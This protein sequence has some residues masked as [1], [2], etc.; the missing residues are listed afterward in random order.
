MERERERLAAKDKNELRDAISIFQNNAH[1][2]KNLSE[3]AWEAS[4]IRW[5]F[6][7]IGFT[8]I[9]FG[10]ALCFYIVVFI[11]NLA[12][13]SMNLPENIAKNILG[14]SMKESGYHL[15]K[16]D[17]PLMWDFIQD[18]VEFMRNN[19]DAIKNCKKGATKERN[20]IECMITIK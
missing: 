5:I 20:V 8:G 19:F 14:R 12:P 4:T 18:S 15:I 3:I 2:L 7:G 9:L 6:V 10:A 1:R 13:E 17:D 11:A 16:K